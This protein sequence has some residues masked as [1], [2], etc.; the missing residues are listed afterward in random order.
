[1]NIINLFGENITVHS[2]IMRAGGW[3]NA[4]VPI[5]I[6][7]YYSVIG[8]WVCKYVYEYL[9]NDIPIIRFSADSDCECQSQPYID[10]IIIC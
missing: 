9:K 6:A 8:G 1:M 3:M 7:P 10:N 2:R 5:L 4:I